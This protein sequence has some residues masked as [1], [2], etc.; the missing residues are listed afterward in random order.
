M[1]ISVVDCRIAEQ[2]GYKE[3]G[4]A[5]RQWGYKVMRL[6]SFSVIYE[7]PLHMCYI[8]ITMNEEKHL[9]PFSG[10]INF[11]CFTSLSSPG[12]RRSR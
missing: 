12:S 8:P 10:L 11:M 6:Y 3:K 1:V 7:D 2:L 9:H 5:K 4:F